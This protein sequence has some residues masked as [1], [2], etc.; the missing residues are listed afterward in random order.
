MEAHLPLTPTFTV[1]G[2]IEP[3]KRHGI[4]LDAFEHL[5]AAGADYRLLVVGQ[6]TADSAVVERLRRHTRRTRVT[7]IDRGDDNEIAN[8]LAHSSAMVFISDAEGYGLPPLEA[9]AAGCPVIVSAGL[10]ALEGLSSAGQL[11]LATVTAESIALAVRKLAD[12]VSNAAFRAA[13]TNLPL[14]S[15]EAFAATTEQWVT[16]VLSDEAGRRVG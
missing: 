4:L 15:W 12:P 9:L 6:P 10:P 2:T 5:W 1:V 16:S 14:P 13:I 3:R 8:A 11:R 7:W